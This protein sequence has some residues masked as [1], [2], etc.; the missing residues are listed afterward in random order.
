MGFVSIGENLVDIGGK[1]ADLSDLA[2][3]AAMRA[4]ESEERCLAMKVCTCVSVCM[5]VC[6]LL[7]GCF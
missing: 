7:V 1:V 4:A 6:L 2:E 5:C 3:A